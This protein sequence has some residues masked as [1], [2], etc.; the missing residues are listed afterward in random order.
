MIRC[1]ARTVL[2]IAALALATAATTEA[3]DR[4]RSYT[5]RTT[6]DSTIK[7]GAVQV[8]GRRDDLIGIATSAAQGRIGR[9]DLRQRPL[10]REG[11][12]LEAVPGMILTQHSGDGKANQMF[13]RGFNLDHGTDFQTRIESMPLNLPTH[14]HGQGYTDLN[15]LIPELVDHVSY[16]LGPYYADLGDFGSAG[17]A[18]L[19]LVRSLPRSLAQ[20]EGGAWGYRR[21]VAAGSRTSGAHTVL[22]GGEAKGYDGPWQVAQGLSKRSALARYSWQGREQAV[23]LLGLSYLNHWNASDQIPERAVNNGAVHR[24]GQVDTSL[25]GST[26]RHSLS[27]DWTRTRGTTRTQLE[28]YAVRYDFELFSN[29]TYHLEDEAAGDQIRQRDDRSIFGLNLQQQRAVGVGSTQHQ[30]RYGLQGRFDNAD[31]SLAHT[32]NRA[33]TDMARADLVQQGSLG[34]W[35][36][37]DSRWQSWLRTSVGVRG[38]GYRFDVTSDRPVN[39]G[40]RGATLASPKASVIVAPTAALELYVG[41]G[42]GFHSN[43]AR[44]TTIRVDPVSGDAVDSVDPLV[45]SRGGE[46]GLRLSGVRDLRT[47]VSLWTLRLDSELLFVGDAGTTEPQG[48]SARTGVTLANFWRPLRALA[49]DADVSFTRARYLDEPVGAQSVPGAL[50]SVIAAGVQWSPWATGPAAVI[51]VRNFGAHPLIEDN[52]VRGRSTTL[53]NASLGMPM[54]GLRLTASV[55]N[56]LGSRGRDVQYFYASRLRGEPAGGVEDV[57]FHPVEPRQLRLGVSFGG[58]GGVQTPE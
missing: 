33:F 42:L 55:L 12:L 22:L 25:G 16:S 51:R 23:S 13:V 19:N 44:G 28:A 32:Q 8:T 2:C 48:R 4:P 21:A 17:G 37:V 38:D 5:S 41:G 35:S 52:S 36:S 30:W 15:L 26:A 39:S 27:L 7:L 18:T 6:K 34:L 49:V 57:H 46:V 50:E 53:V 20:V 40:V 29:F 9:A 47:T 14:A 31:V 54:R 58:W 10:L 3:Q 56:L 11:E 45:R 24:F 43:D 1:S